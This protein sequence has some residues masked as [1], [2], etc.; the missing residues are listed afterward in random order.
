MFWREPVASISF[1]TRC[2]ISDARGSARDC[3]DAA[4]LSLLTLLLRLIRQPVDLTL[5]ERPNTD[6]PTGDYR[7]QGHYVSLPISPVFLPRSPQFNRP[8]P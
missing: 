3:S 1:V 6:R 7:G 4:T 8:S 5:V 2:R